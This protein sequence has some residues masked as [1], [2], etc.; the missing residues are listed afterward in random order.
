M[1]KLKPWTPTDR[2][3][4]PAVIYF[5]KIV[6]GMGLLK[7]LQLIPMWWS[8]KL[9]L[10]DR[11]WTSLIYNTSF[12]CSRE[13]AW[14]L[15]SRE[16]EMSRSKFTQFNVPSPSRRERLQQHLLIPC[17]PTRNAPFSELKAGTLPSGQQ[18]LSL[19]T[20]YLWSTLAALISLAVKYRSG[21]K[22]TGLVLEVPSG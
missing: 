11:S 2:S 17:S 13:L 21:S 19:A 12:Y 7:L 15:H 18:Q 8:R 10:R 22:W 1:L 16:F 5:C 14:G 9:T 6:K 3:R 4:A 20:K